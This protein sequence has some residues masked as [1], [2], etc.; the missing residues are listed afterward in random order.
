MKNFSKPLAISLILF[1]TSL[2]SISHAATIE[3]Q[4]PCGKSIR[5]WSGGDRVTVKI[6]DLKA[7]R[8]IEI[9]TQGGARAAKQLKYR[10]N[11][12]AGRDLTRYITLPANSPRERTNSLSVAIYKTSS[13]NS[14]IDLKTLW[15]HQRSDAGFSRCPAETKGVDSSPRKKRSAVDRGY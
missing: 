5:N 14:R 9:Y 10:N 6:S 7:A 4:D 11:W 8:W 2:S 3:F 13:T 1:S 15:K 12:R